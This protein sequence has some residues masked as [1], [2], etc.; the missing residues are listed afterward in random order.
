MSQESQNH[1]KGVIDR[2]EGKAAVIKLENGQEIIWPVKNLP[3]ETAEG[4][5]VRLVVTTSRTDEE[6][7]IKLA[8]SLLNEILKNGK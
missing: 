1:L 4:S 8:K 7:R 3:E 6:E 2:F 5:A